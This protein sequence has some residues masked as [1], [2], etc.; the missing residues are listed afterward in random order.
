MWLNSFSR[1]QILRIVRIDLRK[2][3]VRLIVEPGCDVEILIDKEQRPEAIGYQGEPSALR[4]G[5]RLR[6]VSRSNMLIRPLPK[7]PTNSLPLAAPK[8]AG[9]SAS[10][11]GEFKGPWVISRLTKL[12][13]VSNTLTKPW[14][15]PGTSSSPAASCLA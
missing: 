14:P 15:G 11:Q 1:L 12:P 10:P 7:L 2:K 4:S 13:L 8:P 3:T 6:P 5:P 9:A